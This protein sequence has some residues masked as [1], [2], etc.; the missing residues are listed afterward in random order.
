MNVYGAIGYVGLTDYNTSTPTTK[1]CLMDYIPQV[2][3]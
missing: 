2:L 1:P 3:L